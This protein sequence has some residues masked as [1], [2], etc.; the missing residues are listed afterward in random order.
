[1]LTRIGKNEM[2]ND[3]M[4]DRKKNWREHVLRGDE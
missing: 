3:N 2:F 1:V 4:G